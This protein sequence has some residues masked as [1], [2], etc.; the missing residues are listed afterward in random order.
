MKR[1][2][3]LLLAA[4][5]LLGLCGC[6]PNGTPTETLPQES[7]AV[8]LEVM[9][10]FGGDDGNRRNYE[11]AVEAYELASGNII[12]DASESSSEEWKARIMQDFETGNEP[13][14]LFYF[15]GADSNAIISAGLV[16]PLEEIR[17]EYPEYAS[18][19]REDM[20]APSMV[21]GKAYSVPV[22]SYVEALYVN[23]TVLAAA[24]VEMPG[25]DYTWS[26]FLLDCQK[27]KDAGYVPIAAS[28]QE[29][30]HYLFEYAVYNEGSR[31]EHLI[32]PNLASDPAGR[33]WVRGL[34]T[35]RDLYDRGFFP[36]NTLTAADAET[37]RLL[38]DGEAA[39]LIDGTWQLGFFRNTCGDRLEDIGITY[40]P[41]QGSRAATDMIG[42]ISMGYYIT[43]KAWDNPKK[44]ETAIRF[45]EYMTSDSVV[46]SFA[47]SPASNPLK[48]SLTLSGELDSLQLEAIEVIEGATSF[49][50]A[51][52][53]LLTTE[54]R[55]ELFTNVKNIVTGR[56]TA[57]SVVDRCMEIQ[58]MY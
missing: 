3:A 10:S 45:I 31:D 55:G 21:D 36:D 56:V 28:L 7:D 58:V 25:A 27:I 1:R 50:G 48:N 40:V 44:R 33:R 29:V 2:I 41:G 5:M 16:V 35:I 18:N 53:D 22:N 15:N 51:A 26:Q 14:V 23:K 32:L 8:S 47:T 19:I 17:K 54:A 9:T 37:V 42:G 52:Q 46:S 12:L 4:A 30:P 24:G 43:R 38:A 34:E 39:F 20:L 49:V 11:A 57:E 13:D 6:T